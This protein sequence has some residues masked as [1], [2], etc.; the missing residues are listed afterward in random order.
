MS[1]WAM[2]NNLKLNLCKSTEIILYRKGTQPALPPCTP[3]LKRLEAVKLLGVTFDQN[4]TFH[5]H[6]QNMLAKG[7]QSLFGLKV[8][9]TH[10][11]GHPFLS[12]VTRCSLRN[13][14]LY[15]SPAWAGFLSDDDR[16]RISGLGRKAVRWGLYRL[17]DP[18]IDDVILQS[19]TRLFR[20][21][22]RN[23]NHVLRQLMPR[24]RPKL[25]HLRR[26]AHQFKLTAMSLWAKRNF[27]NRMHFHDSF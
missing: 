21:I 1:D 24:A 16:Q 25:H 27:I 14:V 2:E 12:R 8:L 26:R 18:T 19:D 6:A 20:S 3:G 17:I 11:L 23:P 22:I 4:L 7:A 13:R 15:A 5:Q 9:K 10:G